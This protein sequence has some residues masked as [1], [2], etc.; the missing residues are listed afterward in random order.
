MKTETAI[1]SI[2]VLALLV[3]LF[4]SAYRWTRGL[5]LRSY[6]RGWRYTALLN[7]RAA[8]RREDEAWANR[9]EIFRSYRRSARLDVLAAAINAEREEALA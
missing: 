6:L 9:D 3:S 5:I 1:A 7:E 8:R 4:V 2:L